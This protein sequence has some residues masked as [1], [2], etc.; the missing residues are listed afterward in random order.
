MFSSQST[1]FI[2]GGELTRL[3]WSKW[4]GVVIESGHCIYN[5]DLS[6]FYLSGTVLDPA[7]NT[8]HILPIYIGISIENPKKSKIV[9][10]FSKKAR[11]YNLFCYHYPSHR[12]QSYLKALEMNHTLTVIFQGVKRAKKRVFGLFWLF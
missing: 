11:F 7:T 1:S 9:H 4:K 6:P 10:F 5:E 3:F 2:L 8:L 12:L